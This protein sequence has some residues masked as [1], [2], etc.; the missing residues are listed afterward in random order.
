M[1]SWKAEQICE[2][3]GYDCMTS[4]IT[5]ADESGAVIAVVDS[6]NFGQIPCKPI[7]EEALKRTEKAA[8][9][10]AAAPA[11][12]EA[13]QNVLN[14]MDRIDEVCKLAGVHKFDLMRKEVEAALFAAGR[15]RS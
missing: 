1:S 8:H 2:H 15:I 14:D 3:D 12:Y 7:S 10:I 9:L 11:M 5:V 13:L 4:G 6:V